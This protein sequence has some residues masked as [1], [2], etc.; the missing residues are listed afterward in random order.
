MKTLAKRMTDEWVP[1]LTALAPDSGCYM[2]EV[3]IRRPHVQHVFLP[4]KLIPTVL[5][6]VFIGR[7][8]NAQLERRLLRAQL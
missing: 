6:R 2:N 8:S 1:A 3:S 4:A 5:T 7:P